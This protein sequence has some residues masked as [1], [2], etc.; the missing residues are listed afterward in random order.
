MCVENGLGDGAGLEQREAQ[1][2]CVSDTCPERRAYITA[3]DGTRAPVTILDITGTEVIFDMNH[4]LAGKSL[5]FE[6]EILSVEE[7]EG[8]WQPPEKHD[9]NAYAAQYGL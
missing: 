7:P 3:D 9:A 4:P 2:H 5:T 1:Q 6:V 8:D